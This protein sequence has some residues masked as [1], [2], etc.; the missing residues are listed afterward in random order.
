[1]RV[2]KDE[3]LIHVSLSVSPVLD[4]SGNIVGATTIARDITERKRAEEELRRASLYARSLIEASLDPLVT[5]NK[6]GRIM[7]VNQ[8][9]ERATGV[10]RKALIGSDFSEYFTDPGESAAGLPAGIREG[11]CAGLPACHPAHL[12]VRYARP[13][14]RQRIQK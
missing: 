6:D 10:E 11:V 12:R 3:R 9:T 7:D 13:V 2:R 14:Q 5:I 8:A 4:E 1:M